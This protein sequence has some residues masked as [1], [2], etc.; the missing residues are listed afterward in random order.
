MK[1]NRLAAIAVVC[2][3][4]FLSEANAQNAFGDQDEYNTIT[5]AVPFL[6]ISP[7]SRAGGM[8]DAGVSTTPDVNSIHWN[9]AKLA[10]MEEGQALSLNYTP[11]LSR[12]VP[13]IN[14]AYLSYYHS[15]GRRQAIGVSMRYFSLGDIT[16][17]DDQGNNIGQFN[18]NEFA[19]DAA[20]ALQLSRN[21]SAGVALRYIYS[22][23][24][25]GQFV[26]GFQSRPGQSVAA[27]IGLYYRSEEFDAGD[28]DAR[29][30]WGISL[31][32]LGARI[33]YT[34]SGEADFIPTNLGVGTGMLFD[35]D[36]YNSF[37]VHLEFN[38]LLVPTPPDYAEDST[39]QRIRDQDGNYVIENGKD[40][41]VP[42]VQGVIQS[43]SDAPGGFQE[44]LNEITISAGVE[45]WYNKQFAVRGGY[46][47]EAQQKGG[48]Q[49]FTLGAGIKYN[50]FGLDFAYLIPAT[51]TVRS[52]LENTLR[53]TLF[54]DLENLMGLSE[55]LN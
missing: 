51:S 55:D 25:G 15:L 30:T 44:E 41:D 32:N 1:Y 31:T 48:R 24:T 10:F 18:P 23:L 21:L 12:L 19:I 36:E 14:L 11:W 8:G 29:W 2:F 28:M 54:F 53:F 16:F 39:G 38:K 7:D 49:Y 13:D 42:P 9:S 35:V 33:S 37:S 5:T 17:T 50:V 26:Q 20:Y 3:S 22:N 47:Y 45:Y 6:R 27:D 52:P 34:E 40:P 4:L 46:F 43:F